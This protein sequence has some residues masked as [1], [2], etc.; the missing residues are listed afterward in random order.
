MT[1]RAA[2]NL[3]GTVS[4]I[5]LIASPVAMPV[6]AQDFYQTRADADSMD[7]RRAGARV[8]FELRRMHEA[9]MDSIRGEHLPVKDGAGAY[10]DPA[11]VGFVEAN[12]DVEGFVQTDGRPIYD[13]AFG[14]E[15]QVRHR[16]CTERTAHPVTGLYGPNTQMEVLTFLDW[17]EFIGV[18][19]PRDTAWANKAW[20]A[21]RGSRWTNH[22]VQPLAIL[23][24]ENGGHVMHAIDGEEVVLPAC[25]TDVATWGALPD[26]DVLAIYGRRRM[27][28]AFVHFNRRERDQTMACPPASDPTLTVGLQVRR[29]SIVEVS[30]TMGDEPRDADGD[31]IPDFPGEWEYVHGCRVPFERETV[32]LEEC[33]MEVAGQTITSLRRWGYRDPRQDRR[34]RDRLRPAMDP[35]GRH[36]RIGGDLRRP[37]WRQRPDLAHRRHLPV[38]LGQLLRSLPAAA[39][40][41]EAARSGRLA[42][43]R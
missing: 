12:Q 15:F 18:G 1:D 34:G 33:E 30:R 42:R 25:L 20:H 29:R 37:R 24:P 4:I 23:S 36:R 13:E 38:L 6:K 21:V 8:V 41:R 26:H 16:I 28:P 11:L 10:T 35:R 22:G 31:L 3:V 40:P 39:G 5:A 43:R 9:L 19:T 27:G 32:V 7:R 2:N 17:D 14:R